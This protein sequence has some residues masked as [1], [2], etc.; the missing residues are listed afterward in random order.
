MVEEAREPTT[1]AAS[2][3]TQ[4]MET[5]GTEDN[6]SGEEP[7]LYMELDCRIHPKLNFPPVG[8][9]E[10]YDSLN[11]DHGDD[12]LKVVK[13]LHG[14]NNLGTFSIQSDDYQRY[15]DKEV[16]VRGIAIPLTCL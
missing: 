3:G 11:I 10:V 12:Y 6:I 2:A 13:E 9:F 1:V 4:I 15:L 14:I 5:E 8:T 16:V 7:I